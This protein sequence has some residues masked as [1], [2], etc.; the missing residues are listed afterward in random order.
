MENPYNLTLRASLFAELGIN[1]GMLLAA[2]NHKLSHVQRKKSNLTQLHRNFKT[3]E[4]I[5]VCRTISQE[6]KANANLLL[7][8]IFKGKA[9]VNHDRFSIVNHDRF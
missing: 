5:Y 8:Y 6:I 7:R 3:A 4:P 1:R 9:I 2:E